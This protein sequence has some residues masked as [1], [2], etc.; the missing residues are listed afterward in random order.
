MNKIKKYK[1]T[2]SPITTKLNLRAPSKT[3]I[4]PNLGPNTRQEQGRKLNLNVQ[5]IS[6]EKLT[7][8]KSKKNTFLERAFGWNSSRAT[9]RIKTLF[10]HPQ[11][12]TR[13]VRET[14]LAQIK[15]SYIAQDSKK[16]QNILSKEL[17]L[18]IKQ[19]NKGRR[20]TRKGGK[21]LTMNNLNELNSQS[22]RSRSNSM[23]GSKQ[24]LTF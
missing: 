1:L 14:K 24:L 10:K 4:E 11:N 19:Y 15:K 17:G 9:K 18:A 22:K 2:H 6:N 13:L 20:G 21:R 12:S 8:L 3:L 5:E 7:N 23:E 16:Q